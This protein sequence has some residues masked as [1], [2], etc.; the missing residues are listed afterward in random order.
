MKR[1][2][3]SAVAGGVVTVGGLLIAI[4]TVPPNAWGQDLHGWADVIRPTVF[5]VATATVALLVGVFCGRLMHRAA[6]A[7]SNRDPSLLDHEEY[8]SAFRA[9]LESGRYNVVKVFGYT[10]EV[11]SNDLI[12]FSDRYRSDLELRVLSRSWLVEKTD[13]DM[14]NQQAVRSGMRPWKKAD[15]IKSQAIASWNHSLRRLARYYSHQPTFKGCLLC[16]PDGPATA[17]FVGWLRWSPLPRSGGSQFKS[18]DVPVLLLSAA[19]PKQQRLIEALESQ[20]DYEWAHAATAEELV[21][22]EGATTSLVSRK[23]P[24]RSKGGTAPRGAG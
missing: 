19:D 20:F 3:T 12:R 14:H 10:G 21:A 22:V 11:V 16:E 24:A 8:V 7:S 4:L 2:K 15:S 5:Y 13:E 6:P 9:A 17:A 1:G 18:V 23:R